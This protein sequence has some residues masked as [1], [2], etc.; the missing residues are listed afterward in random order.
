[1]P[2]FDSQLDLTFFHSFGV[3][4]LI[5]NGK[6]DLNFEMNCMIKTKLNNNNNNNTDFGISLLKAINLINIW[7]WNFANEQESNWFSACFLYSSSENVVRCM[8]HSRWGGFISLHKMHSFRKHRWFTMWFIQ[9]NVLEAHQYASN[10][11]NILQNA[12]NKR[13]FHRKKCNAC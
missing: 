6:D 7:M 9:T 4:N 10:N 5:S 1:M 13:F 8:P 12:W 3:N 11:R 2:H